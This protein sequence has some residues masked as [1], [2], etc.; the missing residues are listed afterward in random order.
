MLSFD[1]SK[2]EYT[3]VKFRE[4]K[5]GL[6]DD[7]FAHL[8]LEVE[9]IIH[10]AWKV[11][12]SQV[13]E[14]YEAEHIHG[15]RTL[16]HWS[17]SS[18]KQPRIVFI[19]SISSVSNLSKHNRD[20]HIPESL[21]K[22]PDAPAEIG[23]AESKFVAENILGTAAERSKIPISILRVGQIA[24]ST[25]PDDPPWPV[26]E[27][28]PSLIKTFKPLGFLPCDL[29]SADWIPIDKVESIAVELMLQ[30]A[31]TS[32]L[33]VYNLV[34][35]HPVPWASLTP[36]VKA[37]CDPQV[38]DVELEDWIKDLRSLPKNKEEAMAKPALKML[39]FFEGMARGQEH[40]RFETKRSENASRTMGSLEP[41]NNELMQMWLNQW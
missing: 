33:Q 28:F 37:H 11:D 1:K 19:S 15:V 7:I 18:K 31:A 26:Q 39:E 6:S 3:S 30:D 38:R 27:W 21:I 14:S 24:D 23:Y 32:D 22:A 12:F 8:S 9:L 16:I 35:P 34:N 20:I 25:V 17:L 10:S 13:L 4:P 29:P 40:G 36:A 5:L 41:V 2:L